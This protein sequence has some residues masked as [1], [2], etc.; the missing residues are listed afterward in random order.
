MAD[1]ETKAIDG[2]VLDRHEV[3]KDKLIENGGKSVSKAMIEAGFS[4]AYASNPQKLKA[5]K[6]WQKILKKYL[7][8]D[9]LAKKHDQLLNS[10]KLDHFVFPATTP[11][12]DIADVFEGVPGAKLITIKTNAQWKRAYFTIPHNEIQMEALKEAY[13]IKGKTRSDGAGI[14]LDPGEEVR[15]VIFRVRKLFPESTT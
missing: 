12:S 4:P 11:D 13:R 14:G 2:V 15:E 10:S 9:K 7:P 3:L 5:T 1:G 8:D 6:K